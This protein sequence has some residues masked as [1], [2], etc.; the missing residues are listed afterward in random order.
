MPHPHHGHPPSEHTIDWAD[1]APRLAAAARVDEPWNTAVARELVRPTDRLDVDVGCGGGGMTRALAHALP[2]GAVIGVDAE[3]AVLAAARSHL[4]A[5]PPGSGVT[6]EFLE[7]DLSAGTAPLAWA[8]TGAPD[9]VW[10]SVSVHHLGDQQAAVDE[11]GRLL[12]PGGRLALA[13]GGLPERTLPW[14]VGVGDPGLEVRLDAAQ[15][16]WFARMRAELPGSV[17]MPYGWTEALRRAGLVDVG[18]R[19]WLMETSPPLAP[20]ARQQIVEKL[21]DR[22]DRLRPTGLLDAA[23]L[24]TWDTLLNESCP[25]W[26]GLREDL[27]RLTA[28]SVHIGTRPG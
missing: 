7:L 15:D 27:G 5:S 8:R 4:A 13:E 20:P 12:A 28:R 23:D 2:A 21:T 9:I 19:S 1:A 17:R 26:L 24:S 3:P 25:E 18:T 10:A 11:L 6:V 16:R 22:V 14:D